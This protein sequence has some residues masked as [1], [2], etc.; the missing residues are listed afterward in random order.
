VNNVNIVLKCIRK[1]LE[2]LDTEIKKVNRLSY[3]RETE[4]AKV[5]LEYQNNDQEEC[6][7]SKK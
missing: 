7:I 2:N 4:Q 5:I 3:Q 6:G 1:Q